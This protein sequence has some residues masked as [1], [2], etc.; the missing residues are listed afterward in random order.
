MFMN[1]LSHFIGLNTVDDPTRI[2]TTAVKTSEGWKTAYPLTQASNVE[3]DNSF[4]L[5]SRVG[6][7]SKLTGTDIH[8]LWSDGSTC[9]FVDGTILYQMHNDYSIT[10]IR[11]GLM[12][13]ARMSYVAV[14]DRVY[15]TNGFQIG[16]VKQIADNAL[17]DP[18]LAFKL[19]LPA[20]KLIEYYKGSLY[21]ACQNILYIADPLCDFFDVRY[22]YKQFSENISMIKAV[23]S[24]IY[25]SDDRIWFVK[26]DGPEEFERREVYD[27]KAIPFTDVRMNGQEIGDGVNGNV[28]I[29]T[30]EN[31]ICLGDNSGNVVNLTEETYLFTPHGSGS[32][33]VR[34]AS[35]ILHYINTLF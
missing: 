24:G 10:S 3:I 30:G 13:G 8:S 15:Y 25:V 29:W 6:Y 9:L 26:G 21:L 35:Q 27:F 18:L 19:T 22:G 33:M 1:S 32:A 7:T 11:T 14:N 20:G 34:E 23:D 16:Y 28:A 4:A 2:G 17:M 5:K 12:S 31:G